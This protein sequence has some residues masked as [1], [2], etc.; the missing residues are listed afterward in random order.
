MDR[1]VESVTTLADSASQAG[2]TT[3]AS[4][5]LVRLATIAEQDLHDD[6]QSAA[7]Y[8]RVIDLDV[9]T[10]EV[11]GAL[12]R[13]YERLGD[14]DQRAR[15]LAMRIEAETEQGGPWAAIDAIYRLAALR[16]AGKSTMDEGAR[17][18]ENALDI[19]PRLDLAEEA[20]RRASSIDPGN[21]KLIALL[22]RI[23][24]E[25]GHERAL[26]E[27]LEL[28]SRLPGADIDTV[29]EAVETAMR[30]GQPG[31]AAS[32]L[33][34]F[35]EGDHSASQNVAN[36]AWAM[37]ALASLRENEGDLRRAVELKRRA[38]QIADPEVARRLDFEVARIAADKLGDLELAAETYAS[39]HERDPADREAWE[40]L[41]AVYRSLGRLRQLGELLARVVD[42]VDEPAER[43]RLRL[44]RVRTLVEG[45]SLGDADALPLLRE[46]V[47][48]DPSQ[49]EAAL[50]LAAILERTGELD[51]LAA[52]LSRQIEAAKDRGDAP[53]IAS[54]ALRLGHLLEEQDRVEAR[55][56]YYTGLDWEPKSRELLDALSNLLAG[57]DDAAERADVLERRL[58]LEHGPTAE[59]MANELAR[60][61]DELGDPQGAQRALEI[62]FRAHPASTELRTRLASAFREQRQWRKLA[63]LCVLDATARVDVGERVALLREAAALRRT[64]L[65]D[66]RG[67]AEA[68]RLAR[69]AVPEDTS[70][71]I[72]LVD[73]W[74]DAGD[75]AAAVTELTAAIDATAKDAPERAAMLATRAGVRGR[76]GDE[77]GALEDMEA[78]FAAD[79]PAYAAGLA[80]RLRA[81]RAAAEH[82]GDAAAARVLRLREAQVLPY[83]GDVEGARA[84]LVDLVKT[85]AKDRSALRTLAGL[86]AALERWDATSAALRRL[87]ALE[88]EPDVVVD[89]ALRLADAC[90]RAERP[91]DA[92]SALERARK[93]APTDHELRQRLEHIYEQ[94]GAWYEMADL[95]LDDAK[96]SGEVEARFASLLRAGSILLERAGDAAAALEPLEEAR[97][98]RPTDP[99]CVGFLADAYTAT[100]RAQ[101]AS[102]LLE[103]IV[104]PLKGKR[105]KE[106]A[107]IYLRIARVARYVGDGAGELR[108]LGQALDCD[109]QNGDVC[110]DV[111]A[112]AMDLDQNELANRALRA[113]TLLKT[114]GAMSKALAYQYMGEIARR[115][116]DPKRALMLLKRAVT[117]DPSLEGAKALIA[118]IERGA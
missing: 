39:L 32:L 107:P 87:I 94:A 3:L 79:R 118:A 71:L 19:E 73:M 102:A 56:V 99:T 22:D 29:R 110:A 75:P 30:V 10:P 81:S 28:R 84:I 60:I 108:A 93:L 11:L 40:P 23:G 69:Q 106:L 96:A 45:F 70:V 111:A 44:E 89:T 51:E 54:L 64:E 1:Y 26:V 2:D 36:L 8:E 14:D 50:M 35:I 76:A 68:L 83:A 42:Y 116:G 61:R 80:G 38:A 86:E 6:R 16:L 13:V 88:E 34:R 100:G 58:G 117:E 53:A 90:E 7:L 4:D 37:G 114:P 105:V 48:E 33:E 91:L 41:V 27:A 72:D 109:G 31:I 101:E 47:D 66:A 82:R 55:N 85:D 46:I 104:A 115:Q 78:A 103:Q 17:M 15:I 62:A 67:A 57:G 49:V 98:L 5:L 113:I 20:L 24:R 112:R 52:L 92:R 25:P 59:T 77:S 63:D 65:G 18:L 9:R 12:D 95:A 43:S 97:A 74:V 21:E